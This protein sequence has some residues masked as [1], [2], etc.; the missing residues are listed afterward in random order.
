LAFL[1]L[2]AFKASHFKILLKAV[3]TSFSK[4]ENE[5]YVHYS[6]F[7]RRLDEWI[8]FDRIDLNSQVDDAL[9]DKLSKELSTKSKKQKV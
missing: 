8:S 1:I 7:D 2:Y 5:Y 6:N 4:E 3:R 9:T